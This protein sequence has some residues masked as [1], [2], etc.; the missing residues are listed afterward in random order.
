[1]RHRPFPFRETRDTIAAVFTD[2]DEQAFT[3]T[4][5]QHRDE[6]RR[7]CVRLTGSP[8]DGDDALQETLLRAWRA[9]R[10]RT[11]SSSRAWLYRIA[12]NACF[13]LLARREPA[14]SAPLDAEPPAPP[15]HGPDAVLVAR[16]TMELAL[17]TAIQ[18]LPPRQRATFVMRDDLGW[19]ADDAAVALAT[20]IHANNSALQRARD[21]LRSVLD[22]SRLE[23]ACTAP[24]GSERE[25]LGRYLSAIEA[26]D[27]GMAAKLVAGG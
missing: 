12:T 22:P 18:H 4:V 10:K 27:S 1:M 7:H 6:L 26:A 15:E 14:A 19:S 25:T 2:P 11:S 23:W 8:A 3:L 13:D 16:E 20:T 5:K 17:L 21:G 9:R 24:C